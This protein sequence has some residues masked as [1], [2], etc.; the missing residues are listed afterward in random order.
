MACGTIPHKS[1]QMIEAKFG[2]KWG[3]E[4]T[5]FAWFMSGMGWIFMISEIFGFWGESRRFNPLKKKWTGGAQWE[6]YRWHT[7]SV[8]KCHSSSL[9]MGMVAKAM[10]NWT[11]GPLFLQGSHACNRQRPLALLKLARGGWVSVNARADRSLRLP[12]S[13]KIH[14]GDSFSFF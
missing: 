4:R 11:F 13:Y 9:R 8:G 2:L 5:I 10:V 12:W 7:S 3:Q 14:C 6:R 1:T